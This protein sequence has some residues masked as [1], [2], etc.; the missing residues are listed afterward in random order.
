MKKQLNLLIGVYLSV[1]VLLTIFSFGFIDPHLSKLLPFVASYHRQAATFIFLALLIL[2]FGCYLYFLKYRPKIWVLI[3]SA[4]ILTFSY[5]ALT[6]DL[7]NYITTAK[8]L[9]TYHENPYIV[10]PIEISNEP[11]LQ[12]TRAANKVALY[13]PIWLFITSLPHT[14]GFG[15]IWATLLAFKLVNALAFLLF[16]VLVYKWTKDFMNVVFFA[17]NPLVLIEVLMNGHNDI[18]MMI[19]VLVALKYKNLLV[20]LA[21]WFIKGAT[22]IV[23]PLLFFKISWDKTLVYAFWLLSFVFFIVGPLREE[24]YPWYAL[25]LITPAALLPYKSHKFLWQFTIVLSFALELR[26]LP[27]MWMGYYEGVGPLLRVLAT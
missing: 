3:T 20:L 27:Y 23:T 18:F 24:L 14:I 26:N 25:W 11:Y 7:F 1:V 15:N 13:G 2:L 21:S 6:Y 4:V 22:M 9:Y 12:F 19:L 10:M 5:P 8:V 16:C 17:F